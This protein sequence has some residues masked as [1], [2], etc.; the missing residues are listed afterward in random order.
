MIKISS[1][2]PHR[3][4]SSRG[5]PET[6]WRVLLGARDRF[7]V[8]AVGVAAL[9][10]VAVACGEKKDYS[11]KALAIIN[12]KEITASEFDLRW[13]QVPEF[14]RKTYEGADGRKKFLDELITRELLLQEAKK[15]G[16]DRERALIERVERFKER[17]LLDNLMREEVDA[18][19]TVTQE[20]IKSY[21]D[22]NQGNFT[23]A[24]E[25]RASHILVKTEAEAAELKKHLAQG[26][27]FSTLARKASLDVSTKSKGGDLGIIKKGQTVPAFEKALLSLKVGEISNPVP[28]QFGYHLIK[29]VDRTPGLPLSFEEAK[30]QVREQVLVEKKR[31]R[32][33]ELVASLRA[34]AKLRVADVPIPVSEAPA[35]TPA[36]SA[37]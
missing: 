36:A 22:A 18:R 20:E 10:S 8:K 9:L 28:T 2:E 15:R 3:D 31:K 24:D 5:R 35:A 23:A 33:D 6:G 1:H 21:Y 27:D 29:L 13:S 17:T 11:S 19:V 25:L 30:E 34:K 37:R 4:G 16:I 12:G 32:F 7:W 26:Q 14:A